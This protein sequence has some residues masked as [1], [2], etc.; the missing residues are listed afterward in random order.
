MVFTGTIMQ[1]AL[2]IA[3][4]GWLLCNGQ[5]TSGYTA[6]AAIVGG[7]VPDLR[8]RVIVGQ[9]SGTFSTLLATG[10]EEQHLLTAAESG[11]VDHNH[12]GG[13]G[14]MD[15]NNTH[16]HDATHWHAL[17]GTNRTFASKAAGNYLYGAQTT[18]STDSGTASQGADVDHGHSIPSSGA[19]ALV[20]HN[21]LQPYIVLNYIIKT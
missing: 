18:T 12:G 21:N 16:T 10:G 17:G 5:S 13:T 7:T 4:P 6:L 8:G 9:N 3:P 1:Y 2:P 19:D 11:L 20:A 15:R 14:S